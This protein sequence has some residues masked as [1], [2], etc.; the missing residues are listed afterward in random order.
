MNRNELKRMVSKTAAFTD[1]L[2]KHGLRIVEPIS[3]LGDEEFQVAEKCVNCKPIGYFYLTSG[4]VH[5]REINFAAA[6]FEQN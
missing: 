4:K 6:S 1:A 3:I 5:N 2:K